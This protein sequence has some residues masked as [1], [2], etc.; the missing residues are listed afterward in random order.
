MSKTILITGASSGIGKE[1]AL[2]LAK[3]GHK[4]LIHGRNPE[5]TQQVYDEIVKLVGEENVDQFIADLSLKSEVKKLATNIKSK[6][7]QLDVLINNAGGQFGKYREV[8][9]EGHEKTMAINVI[10]PFLLTYEL[11]DILK[12]SSS[13]RVVTVSS[14]SYSMAGKAPLNDIE[15]EHNYSMTK[16]YAYSKRYIIWI[17]KHYPKYVKQKGIQNI[18]FNIT[19]PGSAETDLGRIS[20]QDTYMK[21]LAKLWKPMM[22]S[23]E[24]AAATSIYLAT[25]PKV[26]GVTGKFFGNLKEKRVKTKYHSI[27]AEHTLWDYCMDTTEKYRN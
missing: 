10:A 12:E 15:L 13:A 25:S 27:E 7:K 3:Q 22:W 16:A 24:K 4:I 18:T 1:T 6:Y 21:Y 11:L 14:A 26:E 19:E 23:T 9:S 20:T 8:T 2:T 5:R 17:M